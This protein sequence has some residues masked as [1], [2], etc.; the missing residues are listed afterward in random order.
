MAGVP[1]GRA[2]Q[3][4]SWHA[5]WTG[6]RVAVLG[7]G[8]TGFSVADTLTELGARVLVVAEKAKQEYIDLVPVIGAALVQAPAGEIPAELEAHDP[9]LVVV[10]PGYHPDDPLLVWAAERGIPVW[11]DVELAWRVRDKVVDAVTGRPADWIAVTGTNGKTTTTQLAASMLLAGG[12]R[13]APCG[14]IGIPVLDAIRDPQGFDV[15]VVELSSYQLHSTSSMSAHS[16]VVLNVAE[17]HLDWHGSFEAY[18]AAKARVYDAVQVACVYNKA[19]EL[20]MRMVEEAEVV[21]GARA[22]GFGLGV[23]GPS[24]F[25]VVEGILVDRAFLDERR[26]SALEIAT[27]TEL[28]ARGLAAP[29]TVADVLAAAALA[30]AYGVSIEAIRAALASFTLDRHRI[31]HVVTAGGITWVD[32]SKATNPHAAAASL[33]AYPSIVWIVGGL[34]KGVDVDPFVRDSLAGARSPVRAVVVIGVDRAELGDAIRRHAPGLPLFEVD[35]AETSD[36]MADAV[37]LAAAVASSGD[38]VLLAPA[39]ASMDQFTDYADRGDRFAAAVRKHVG[40]TDGDDD[41][42]AH[43]PQAGR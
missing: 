32:D 20:T 41:L 7:L 31:E 18:A 33:K 11:G 10:S 24:D 12:H 5:D 13:V 38:V 39:A 15:L 36:V 21:E 22:I 1:V 28:A 43:D 19:D 37:A 30:R 27:V 14:N 42:P 35:H 23:P 8:V 9:E 25:G 2:E 6:L 3:L 40:G 17:D 29:H 4:T 34:L 26:D 16:A